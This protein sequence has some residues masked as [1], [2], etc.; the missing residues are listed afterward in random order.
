MNERF[1]QSENYRK[2]VL[3]LRSGILG[4]A[5]GGLGVLFA[6]VLRLAY[7]A[8]IAFLLAFLGIAV[9]VALG[10]AYYPSLYTEIR[11]TSSGRFIL[12][13]LRDALK[14]IPSNSGQ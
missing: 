8:A 5:A 11:G 2:Y 12:G 4:L 13:A 9:A 3:A 10:I 6:S 7:P 14:G 1:R